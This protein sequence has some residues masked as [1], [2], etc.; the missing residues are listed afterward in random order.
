MI[1]LFSDAYDDISLDTW[2]A[3]WDQADVEDVDIQG[4]AVK[5]YRNLVFA[6]IEFTSE[7]IDATEMTH[8]SFDMWTPDPTLDAAFKVK[9]VDFGPDGS[10][11]G[12]DDSE[13]EITI[14]RA[15]DPALVSG[16]WISY[17]IP[18]EDFTGLAAR[19]HLAQLIIAGDPN[20]VYLDNI[21]FWGLTEP[22]EAAP[23]PDDEEDDV[24]SL[25][26]DAYDDVKV[27]TWSA[28][29]DLA[30]VEDVEIEGNA[31]KKYTNLVFAGIEFTSETIDATEMTHFR[32][33]F[34]TPDPTLTAAF[35]VKLVDFGEDGQWSGGDDSEHEITID[36]AYDPPLV[37]G[38]WISFDIPLSEITG[39]EGQA[40]LAQLII[41]GDPNTV[42][43]DNVYLRK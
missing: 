1:S 24:I 6:G 4:D 17:E 19:E 22:R 28:P 23:T 15:S 9:L 42:F 27:D 11:S 25:F 2:S 21:Y 34:W 8:F 41:S 14:T 32:F 12:G 29:W 20:T 40:H 26:S 18:F 31:T 33:D 10:W 36:R 16:E 5:K 30:D 37:S 35:K 39:L 7:T 3:D 13:H 38:E 43:L